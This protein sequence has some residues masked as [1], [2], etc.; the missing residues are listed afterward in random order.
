MDKIRLGIPETQSLALVL[1]FLVLVFCTVTDVSVNTKGF[2]AAFVAV[3][4]TS[5]QQY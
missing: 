5:L 2:V 4:S 1:F 3:W